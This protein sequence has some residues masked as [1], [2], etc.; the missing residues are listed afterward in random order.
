MLPS[1]L[2]GELSAPKPTLGISGT[3]LV[4]STQ[5][6]HFYLMRV[7]FYNCISGAGYCVGQGLA[8]PWDWERWSSQGT[9]EQ[10][11]ISPARA[12]PQ[13]EPGQPG[14]DQRQPEAPEARP[15]YQLV[16]GGQLG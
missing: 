10:G 9:G 3:Q 5:D 1:D 4:P 16:D 2:P 7:M 13:Q 12:H 15:E 6:L 11:R 8:V 14:G